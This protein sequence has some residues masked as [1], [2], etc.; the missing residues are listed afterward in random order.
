MPDDFDNK[1]FSF[2]KTK[3]LDNSNVTIT[4]WI[5][6]DTSLLKRI[7]IDSDLTITPSILSIEE[8]NFKIVS[9]LHEVTDYE[10]YGEPVQIT[11]PSDAKICLIAPKEPI[12]DG[13]SSA[14]WSLSE[15]GKRQ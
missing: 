13:R 6:K 1:S 8:A 15:G 11:L 4:A 2:D 12:G 10:N 7:E 14:C 3:L 9:T 5:A